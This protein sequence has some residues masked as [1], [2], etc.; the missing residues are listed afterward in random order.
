[1]ASQI[2]NISIL[3]WLVAV[4]VFL[5]A[6]HLTSSL[7]RHKESGI[8][9]LDTTG[10]GS[11]TLRSK[12]SY[13]SQRFQ[14]CRD[15]RNDCKRLIDKRYPAYYCHIYKGQCDV[16]CGVAQCLGTGSCRDLISGFEC[17]RAKVWAKCRERRYKEGCLKTCC[18]CK[19]SHPNCS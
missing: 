17:Y 13:R 19:P 18:S 4:T 3:T 14:N 10:D 7:P 1:M 6:V 11:L 9:T 2:N 15:K 12:R 16:T 8:V 5:S